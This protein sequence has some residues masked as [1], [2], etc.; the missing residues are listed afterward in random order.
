MQENKI[1]NNKLKKFYVILFSLIILL[2]PIAFLFGIISD[3]ENYKDEAIKNIEQSWAKSQLLEAPQMVLTIGK[4]K[5][6]PT[7][8]LTLGDYEVN[9][10]IK[11]EIRKKGIF[12]VP[13]YTANVVT[14]GDFKNPYGALK[15]IKSE[16]TFDVTDSKGF[17]EAPQFKIFNED[18]QTVDENT[19]TKYL[20]TNADKIPF[21]ITY[22]IRGLKKISVEP[23]GITSKISINGNWKDPSFEG[24]Y[25]P[26]KRS[27]TNKD[28]NAEWS[29]P[30]IATLKSDNNNNFQEN[31]Y[32]YDS[33][34]NIP[35]VSV[36]LL[37]PVDNYRMATR[38]V[39]YAFLFLLL[40][41][42]AYYVFEITAKNN[43]PIHP[44]QYMLM[45]GALLIF[46]LLLTSISEFTPFIWAYIISVLFTVGLISTYTYFVLTKKENPKFTALISFVMLLL[47]TFL[48]TLL[49][50]QDLSLL[51]GSFILF[52]VIASIMY[53]TRNVEWYDGN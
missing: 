47:Y 14:K 51:I 39:K 52:A 8:T 44:I 3:R 28:F 37:T 21:E 16:L 24:N 29:I 2:I 42:V 13:V 17:V 38:S 18:Y 41:F 4:D 11:T 40:T 53:A 7:Q 9:V 31:E 23:A 19:Y 49:V 32:S 25:L 36:S 26:L 1:F 12:K 27:V 20:T 33:N 30:K 34:T 46:Y 10:N 48:Y 45:G 15:N 50:I 35:K 22:K 5:K 43:T 6:N